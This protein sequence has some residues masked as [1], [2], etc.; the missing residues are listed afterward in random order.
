MRRRTDSSRAVTVFSP[1]VLLSG[2]LPHLERFL[3][4]A[5]GLRH[6]RR[7][8]VQHD[9]DSITAFYGLSGA[10]SGRHWPLVVDLFEGRLACVTEWE[11]QD[12]LTQLQGL[13]GATQPALAAPDTLRGRFWCDNPVCNLVHVSDDPETMAA[14]ARVLQARFVGPLEP[15]ALPRTKPRPRHSALLE[16]NRLLQARHRANGDLRGSVATPPVEGLARDAAEAAVTWLSNLGA[17]GPADLGELIQS[18]FEGDPRFL[19]LARRLLGRFSAWEALVLEC[20]L[21]A[22]PLWLDRLGRK[23]TAAVGAGL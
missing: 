22:A 23:D 3:A 1:E 5:T 20:G 9:A 12:A 18:F 2:L 19:P 7:F 6:S 11:G 16:L 15:G 8:L 21:H 10:T 17:Q 4:D 14:E 13:K